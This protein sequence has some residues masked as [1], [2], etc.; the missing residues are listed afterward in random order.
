MR[1]LLITAGS[2]GDVEPFA[3]LTRR[4]AA[5]GHSPRL[6]IPD[7]SG[8]DVDG[9]EVASVGV[10][11]RDMVAEVGVSP[12]SAAR[13][14]REII[15]PAMVRIFEAG[16]HEVLNTRPDVVVSHPKVLT[17]AD[18]AAAVGAVSVLVHSV[19]TT[20]PTREFPAPGVVN[21]N[22]MIG[23][24]RRI[25]PGPGILR[26]KRRSSTLRCR[27]SSRA[28]HSFSRASAQWWEGTRTPV[29]EPS[30]RSPG[31]GDSASSS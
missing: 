20:I 9:L 11:F 19:P 25:S 3:V 18:A 16:V 12:L 13:A 29:A 5:E 27:P 6:V 15:R 8:I 14:C 22:R 28:A 17:A 23:L 10:N 30:L 31:P 24:T 21:I 7:E 4:L 2:R 26:S 1:V